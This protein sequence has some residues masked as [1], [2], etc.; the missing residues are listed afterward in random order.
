MKFENSL[1]FARTLDKSDPLKNF[2]KLFYIPKVKVDGKK[3]EAIYLCGNSLGL[4]PKSVEGHLKVELNDWKKLGVE[5]HLHGKNPWF[6]YH[7]FFSK[8]VSK[9]V[10]AK[11][12]EVVVMNQLTVNLNLLLIS[13]YRPAGKRKKILVQANEFP[14]DYYAIEQQIKLHGLNPEEC[15]V[16][17]TPRKN[18]VTLRTEDIIAKIEEHKEELALVMFSAVNYY[19]GQLFEIEK[20]AHVCCKHK[21]TFG[22][23]L[24]HAIGNVELKLHDW[25]ID[26][27]TWCSYKY[28]N[29]GPGGVSGVFVHEY[30]AK[31]FELPRLAGWWGNNEETRFTMPKHFVPQPG[32][33]GWQISNA[34]VLSMA[35]HKASLEIF[36]KAGM[37]ALRKKSE[38]LT[39]YLEWLLLDQE[40]KNKSPKEYRVITPKSK[41]ERGCQLSIQTGKNGKQ[42]FQKLTKAGVIADWREP[43]V[44]RV[45]PVPLYNTFENVFRFAQILRK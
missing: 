31:N 26:F 38:L 25:N 41:N 14:S 37:K 10:G 36:D 2:R 7:H 19:T 4:Q 44:I 12:T 27:A 16:E 1:A 43:D 15:I 22:V 18:E 32:A 39:G 8:S 6:Y 40:Q 13:F 45:A 3:Q 28:L 34:P 21:I 30:H 33:A 5:G 9:L 24:A 20:I 17:V 29:S 23:D 35:A 42:L 11:A